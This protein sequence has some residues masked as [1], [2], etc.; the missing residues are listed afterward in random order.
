MPDIVHTPQTFF[1]H[2]HGFYAMR[3]KEPETAEVVVVACISGRLYTN[4][5][6]VRLLERKY[7]KFLRWLENQQLVDAPLEIKWDIIKERI[8]VYV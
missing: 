7:R 3:L 8:T 5:Q 4:R 6:I 2:E 1:R